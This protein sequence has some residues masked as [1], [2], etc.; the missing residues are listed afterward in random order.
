MVTRINFCFLFLILLFVPLKN[1][2]AENIGN[3][4][5]SNNLTSNFSNSSSRYGIQITPSSNVTV[6]KLAVVQ[7]SSGSGSLGRIIL[8]LYSDN[9]SDLPNTL[10]GQTS[11]GSMSYGGSN[12]ELTLSSSINLTANTKY[13]I[14]TIPA[15]GHGSNLGFKYSGS[16]GKY[17]YWS[18]V[19]GQSNP[20]TPPSNWTSLPNRG[21]AQT[22]CSLGFYAVASADTTAPTLSSSSPAVNATAVSVNANIVIMHLYQ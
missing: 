13:W 21:F 11:I 10:L 9:G 14:V 5:S 17:I 22:C 6:S 4:N 15:D 20:T 1:S 12:L 8:A 7:P 19:S 2:F 18:S 3:D 16:T